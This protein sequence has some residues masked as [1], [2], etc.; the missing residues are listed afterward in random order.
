MRQV[1]RHFLPH[2]EY[3][4]QQH[5]QRPRSRLPRLLLQRIRGREIEGCSGSRLRALEGAE[6]TIDYRLRTSSLPSY[7]ISSATSLICAEF[8]WKYPSHLSD[9]NS[10]QKEPPIKGLYVKRLLKSGL[11]LWQS[12]QRSTYFYSISS[13]L[14]RLLLPGPLEDHGNLRHANAN[15]N[16]GEGLSPATTYS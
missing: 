15:R 16:E 11:H 12:H 13:L 10:A 4:A 14:L 3:P 2:R 7:T 1:P 9:P 8:A 6:V 5:Y